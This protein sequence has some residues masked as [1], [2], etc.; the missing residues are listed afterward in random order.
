[1]TTTTQL[2]KATEEFTG[3][4]TVTK[5]CTTGFMMVEMKNNDLA[6]KVYT[7]WVNTKGMKIEILNNKV[8]A[9]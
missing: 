3:I 6:Q 8:Y 5:A 4:N 1:M 2:I 7:V 9:F